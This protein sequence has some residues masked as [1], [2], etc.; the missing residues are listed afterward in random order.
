M[1]QKILIAAAA[2]LLVATP[3]FAADMPVKAP[4]AAPVAV[5]AVYNWT[6]FYIGGHAGYGWGE[7]NSTIL[8][9]SNAFPAGTVNKNEFDGVL[10]GGQIGLNY[11]TGQ[12]VFG[13]EADFSWSDIN[14]DNVHPA[15]NPVA[16]QSETHSEVSWVITLTGRLGIT[17]GPAL[18]Y[19]K[20]GG[21]W[22]DFDSQSQTINTTNGDI[23]Q[24]TSGGETRFGWIVGGGLEYAFAGN[25]SAKVEYNY[26]D[27]G[28][29]RV[30]R[31]G[32]NFVNDEPVTNQRDADTHLHI[33]KFGI[34]YR[35]GVG[36]PVVARY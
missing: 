2:G 7:T 6:G 8:E 21:A 5:A 15:V 27:F 30:T 24:A 17:T 14:G 12:W 22:A 28:K 11:Q 36:G 1:M 29:E 16:R 19:V 25:W 33:V 31:S 9:S 3:T 10:A 20:G 26:L 23:T 4:R 18:F 32:Y 34:N 35:F 13:V